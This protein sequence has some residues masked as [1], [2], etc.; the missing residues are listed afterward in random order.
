MDAGVADPPEESPFLASELGFP[1]DELGLEGGLP[2][3]GGFWPGAGL[4]DAGAV[5][6]ATILTGDFIALGGTPLT[7]P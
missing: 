6:G 7:T 1:L 4:D 3:S 5:L 2:C